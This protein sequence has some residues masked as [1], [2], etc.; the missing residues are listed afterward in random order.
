MKY[1]LPEWDDRVDPNYDFLTDTYSTSHSEDA[2]KHDAYIWDIF[3]VENVPI[4]GVLVSRSKVE[5]N[6]TKLRR[7]ME[8]GIH[9]FLHLPPNFEIMGDCGAFGYI[10]Q[11]EPPFGTKETLDYYINCRFNYGVSIDHLIVPKFAEQ[12]EKRWQITVD[13]AR[14]MYNLWKSKDEYLSNLRIIGIAQGWDVPSYRRS[15]RELL[16]I[17]YDYIGVGGLARAPTGQIGKAGSTKTVYNV[18]YGVVYE[19]KK[20][21]ETKKSK[22]DIHIFGFA[23]PKLVTILQKMGVS[24]FD[25]ASF[26]RSAWLGEDGGKYFTSK[27]KY[28]PIRVP[29]PRRSPRTSKIVKENHVSKERLAHLSERVVYTLKRFEQGEGSVED[30]LMAAKEYGDVV[31]SARARAGQLAKE[32]ARM[33]GYEEVLREHPWKSCGCPICGDL[34]I[35]VVVFRGNERNRRRGFHNT[36]VFYRKFRRLSPKVIVF[37]NCTGKK[38]ESKRLLPAYRRY[39]PSPVFKAFWNQV[40]DLPVEIK[41]LS[42]KYGLIDFS[43]R[44]PYYDYKMQEEDV[45]K[46][47]KELEEKLGRY[48]K[49]FFIGLGLYRKAVDKVRLKAKIEV[50]PKLDLTT[51]DKLDIIEYTKQ[52]ALF[53]QAILDSIGPTY[54]SADLSLQ[55]TDFLT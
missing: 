55:L 7:I 50:F 5:E 42:A 33:E 24:S 25:S 53:R 38:D 27:K 32:Q 36:Y 29:D 39:L 3:G 30:C 1:F 31:E 2:F 34:G 11:D 9:D 16:N 44:I 48:D 54:S 43:K 18:M 49:I 19:V 47:A 12:N 6:K 28:R 17:G 41:I 37:T 14:E 4:D 15:V 21:C 23:R 20:W 26:L 46:F 35:E 45:P 8:Q 52:M 10:E 40:Y 13:N 51:R 22:V